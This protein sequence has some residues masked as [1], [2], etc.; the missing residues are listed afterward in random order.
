MQAVKAFL[1]GRRGLD[2][3]H[4]E[5]TNEHPETLM[6]TTE[7]ELMSRRP[8]WGCQVAKVPCSKSLIPGCARCQK[9]GALCAYRP[10]DVDLE[11]E[12]GV[13]LAESREAYFLLAGKDPSVSFDAFASPKPTKSHVLKH[14]D[15]F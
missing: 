5:A 4:S 7:D 9:I 10:E 13:V 11:P 3:W 12:S 14:L 2:E 8:C 1:R 15:Y 6:E